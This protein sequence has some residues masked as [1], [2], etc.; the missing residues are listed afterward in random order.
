M[1]ATINLDTG[2]FCRLGDYIFRLDVKLKTC[3][4]GERA[5]H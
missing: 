4:I 2:I 1:N 5:L 3:H